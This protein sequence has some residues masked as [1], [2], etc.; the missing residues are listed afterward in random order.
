M[1]V[2]MHVHICTMC[3]CVSHSK[4]D[5]PIV[6]SRMKHT[7]H[8]RSCS[9]NANAS[10]R[11]KP[12]AHSTHSCDEETGGSE[13][14]VM[15]REAVLLLLLLDSEMINMDKGLCGNANNGVFFFVLALHARSVWCVLLPQHERILC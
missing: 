6:T 1:R 9:N 15:V 10:T 5:I 4:A 11:D 2:C 3:V 8:C 12:Q 7:C 13:E 14:S